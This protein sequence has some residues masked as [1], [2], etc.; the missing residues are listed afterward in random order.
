MS[1]PTDAVGQA[2]TAW[3]KGLWILESQS[4]VMPPFPK[5]IS[6]VY[7]LAMLYMKSGFGPSGISSLI[8]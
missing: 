3:R 2:K 5:E 7:T 4:A 1:A 8:R 6:I